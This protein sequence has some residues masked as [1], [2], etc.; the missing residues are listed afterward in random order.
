MEVSI[1]T[2]NTHGLP[3]SRGR[4]KEI[5]GWLSDQNADIVCLQE[6]FTETAKQYYI[7]DLARA[8]YAVVVPEDDGLTPVG[9]GLL[10]M[11]KARRFACES[12]IFC[13]YQDY[14]NVEWFA[15]KGF[16]VLRLIGKNGRLVIVNTHTQSNTEVSFVFGEA[17]IDKIRRAQFKQI[18]DFFEGSRIP[19]LIVGDLNCAISPYSEVRFLN[20][21]HENRF[22]KSTFFSTGEDL[23]HVAWM[24][25][26]YAK[27][28]C[29]MCDIERFGPKLHGCQ[30]YQ[31]PYSDHAPVLYNIQVPKP[32]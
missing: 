7:K 9:S 31:I 22:H 17:I 18:K 14:H 15:N 28:G 32:L 11:C 4:F 13:S 5:A 3:W 12:S 27:P 29:S 24:P 25:C 21:L 10:T 16:H 6:V 30:V 1:I 23:D 20:V 8:G 26:Q 19:V 2:Y